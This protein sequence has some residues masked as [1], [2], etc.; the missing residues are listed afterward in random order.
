MSGAD[1]NF[2]WSHAREALTLMA[3][4]W[5][6]V[7]ISW[8]LFRLPKIIEALR[9]FNDLRTPIWDLRT[10]VQALLAADLKGQLADLASSVEAAQKQLAELQRHSADERALPA[11]ADQSQSPLVSQDKWEEMRTIWTEVR[12]KLEQ[13]IDDIPDGRVRRK[14]DGISRYSYADISK[15]LLKDGF[16]DNSTSKAIERMNETFLSSRRRARPITNDDLQSFKELKSE[17]DRQNR[18]RHR[19]RIGVKSPSVGPS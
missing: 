6:L 13:L 3:I 14:Y 12:E 18:G 8:A 16:I 1:I 19:E 11:V 4:L 2:F 7:V 5:A 15:T 17:F 10:S 9:H